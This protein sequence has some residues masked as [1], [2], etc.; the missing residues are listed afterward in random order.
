MGENKVAS[1]G[2]LGLAGFALT[3]FILNVFNAGLIEGDEGIVWT[4]GIFFGGIAQMC[5]GMWDIK[6]NDI[7]GGTCFTAY[8]AFWIALAMAKILSGAG[9]IGAIPSG[10]LVTF[11]VAWG[12]FTLYATVASIKVNKAVFTLF[13]T[14]TILFFLLAIGVH[15]HTVHTI[16]GYEG[17]VVALIAF[18]C[19]AATLVNTMHG[20]ELLPVGAPKPVE[21]SRTQARAGASAAGK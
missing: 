3:T 6:R 1:P 15:N 9:I 13:V 12:I 20:K 21:T 17:I 10:A 2:A 19:S 18:Y 16:A 5:A 4:T 8:G 7:F 14:L 11:L